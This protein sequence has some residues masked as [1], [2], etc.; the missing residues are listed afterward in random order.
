MMCTTKEQNKLPRQT[1]CNST[2]SSINC[3]GKLLNLNYLPLCLTKER[4]NL[5]GQTIAIQLFVYISSH[6]TCFALCVFKPSVK[7]QLN[8]W[9]FC[10]GNHY[11]L[12]KIICICT[13]KCINNKQHP[14]TIHFLLNCRRDWSWC[15]K[16]LKSSMLCTVGF[17]PRPNRPWR[18][19]R[20]RSRRAAELRRGDKVVSQRCQT[21]WPPGAKQSRRHVP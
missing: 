4:K 14:S 17:D 20:E 12:C 21:R 10:N 19:V 3:P 5:P 16:Y 8:L 2:F 9:N 15:W 1:F 7:L 11:L 6:S 18:D 13:V